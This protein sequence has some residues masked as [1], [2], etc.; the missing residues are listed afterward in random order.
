M[1]RSVCRSGR[2]MTRSGRAG[3]GRCAGVVARLG[4][5]VADVQK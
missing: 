4:V 2:K 5:A 3:G 1:C